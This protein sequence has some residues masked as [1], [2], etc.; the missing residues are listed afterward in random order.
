NPLDFAEVYID[1]K[2]DLS[3]DFCIALKWGR[4]SDGDVIIQAN[5][6]GSLAYRFAPAGG[7]PAPPIA[8]SHR[9]VRQGYE[10]SQKTTP[11]RAYV[12][13]DGQYLPAHQLKRR[14]QAELALHPGTWLRLL[15][16]GDVDLQLGPVSGGCD[17]ELSEDC[18]TLT[19]PASELKFTAT[20]EGE[21]W[22]DVFPS[23]ELPDADLSR[24]WNTFLLERTFSYHPLHWSPAADWMEWR[25]RML[26]WIWFP[27]LMRSDLV[28]LL[29]YKMTD[30]GYVYTWGDK[31]EWP[32]P[33]NEKYDA[34][35]FT[36]NSNYILAC[37]RAYCWSGDSEFL[38]RVMPRVRK[39][40]QWQLT[41]CRGAEG[42][43]IDNSPDHDGT[44]RAV[45]SNYWDDIPFGYKSAYEN[46]YFYASLLA[47]AELEREYRRLFGNPA[48]A[49]GPKDAQDESRPPEYYT[50]LARRVHDN[51][52]TTFWAGDHYIACVDITGARHDYGITY[53]NLEAFAYGLGDEEKARRF[54]KWLETV[55][56]ESGKPDM[57]HFGFAPRVNAWDLAK[58]WWYLEGKGEIKPTRWGT[59]C[60]NGGAILYTSHYDILDRAMYLS[61]ADAI[62]RMKGIMRRWREPDRLCGGSPMWR[63]EVTG[64]AVGTDIPFPESGLAA[65][66]PVYAF[67]G[68]DARVDGLL[69]RPNLD[70]VVRSVAARGVQWRGL[71]MNVAAALETDGYRV[72]VKV[73]APPECVTERTWRVKRGQEVVLAR[74]LRGQLPPAPLVSLCWQGTWIWARGLAST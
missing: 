56:T 40:M 27:G 29:N 28:Y 33:D 14:A 69:I 60:E 66:A 52:D 50:D 19:L 22:L 26:Y 54:Y 58:T 46:I 43:F 31:P 10:V 59:H 16:T 24:D 6:D 5:P 13:D 38:R 70:Q 25:A 55:V 30:D 71:K 61:P 68:L 63:Q 37:W 15:G 64:W 23:L 20:L 32:F 8:L 62:E 35:H 4:A 48:G 67:L 51:Y 41:E 11:V 73:L 21:R 18:L 57:Y 12:T 34:R 53:V 65:V 7:G 3:M 42:L 49:G 47:M 9:W 39:A 2:P 45:H 17:I 72:S 44:T 1:G 36:T 74:P